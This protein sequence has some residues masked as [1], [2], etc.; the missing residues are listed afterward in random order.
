VKISNFT[1][2]RDIFHFIQYGEDKKNRDSWSDVQYNTA[3]LCLQGG[4][5]GAGLDLR[6]EADLRAGG[7]GLDLPGTGSP[8]RG[9][10]LRQDNSCSGL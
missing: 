2:E 10:R 8:R 5:A 4:G 7:P 1:Q 3:S 9:D 6:H